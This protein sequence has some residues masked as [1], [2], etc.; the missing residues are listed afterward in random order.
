MAAT[1]SRTGFD[2]QTLTLLPEAPAPFV[3]RLR[4]HALEEFLAL[5]VPSQETEEWR[6]TDLKDFDFG[7]APWTEGGRARNLDD[8]P[9]EILEAAGTVGERAGLQ[10]QRNS[11][12]MVTH[13]D[14][15]LERQGVVLM[16]LDDAARIHP[17]LVEPN[18]HTLIPTGRTRFTALHGAFRSGGTFLYVPKGVAIQ[19]PLQTLTYLDAD[20][21]A[22]FPHTLIVADEDSEV[23]FIDRLVSPD[24]SRALSDAVVE[25]HAGPASRVRYVCLQEWGTGVQ[26]LSVQRA[27][28]ARDAEFRSLGVAFG[29]DLARSE[30]ES[31]L[32]EPGGFSEMLGVYFA[33]GDQHFDH[34]ALQDH[35]APSCSSNLLYKGA[36]KER[37]N[38]VYSGW[39]N[40]RPG[41]Q[42]TD[43]FQTVRNIVLSENAKAASIPNLEI[44]ANDVR[45]GHA[46]SDGPVE[47]DTL[48]YLESRGIPRA[49]AE[50]L[51]VF[52]F[53]QEV[54]DKITLPE[55][56][57][58]ISNAIEAELARVR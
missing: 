51:I 3:D 34:R 48:F 12:V 37:S 52:G 22:V 56:R 14:P 43:A 54:L 11:E 47:E 20:G 17:D 42:K 55:V 1:P 50:R 28:L 19:L 36:L 5:P 25:V 57:E 31:V 2:E 23:T 24:L 18:L 10:I 16:D 58:G 26:H 40:V 32:A 49:E 41:A 44:Q 15:E 46:A 33:D 38:A 39:V 8:V 35:V 27:Q 9:A 29:G 21:G 7:F 53:F 13:L 4:A 30:I 45:C 6:Y